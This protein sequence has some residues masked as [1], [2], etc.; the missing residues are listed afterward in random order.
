[1]SVAKFL[2]SISQNFKFLREEEYAKNATVARIEGK[3]KKRIQLKVPT[4]SQSNE[5]Y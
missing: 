4:L 2:Q 1:M 5:D 3:I